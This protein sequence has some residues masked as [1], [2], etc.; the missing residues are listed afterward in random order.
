M[1]TTIKLTDYETLELIAEIENAT[2]RAVPVANSA[3]YS[4]RYIKRMLG[5]DYKL[6][7]E[8]NYQ[9]VSWKGKGKRVIITNKN[10]KTKDLG[11]FQ[12]K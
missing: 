7:D 11:V 10:G 12:S 2:A 5:I 9:A 4:F 8:E 6:Y 3:E 1:T